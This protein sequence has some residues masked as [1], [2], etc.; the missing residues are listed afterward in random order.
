MKPE[1]DLNDML[2][3][4]LETRRQ[5][6]AEKGPFA[7]AP[8]HV[9]ETVLFVNNAE[10]NQLAWILGLGERDND[11]M[12]LAVCEQCASRGWFWEEV[13]EEYMQITCKCRSDEGAMAAAN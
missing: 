9:L 7:N 12:D 2:S 8:A 11:F 5:L 3:A 1:T 13:N 4:L 10:I 6:K